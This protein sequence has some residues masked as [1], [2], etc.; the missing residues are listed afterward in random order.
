MASSEANLGEIWRVFDIELHQHWALYLVEGAVL[1]VLGATAIVLPPLATLAITVMLGWVLL[2]SGIIGLVTT[3]GAR[4][5][6]GFGWSLVSG[7]LAVAV[8]GVLLANAEIAAVFLTL[9]LLGFFIIE[10]GVS[11]MFALSHRRRLSSSRWGWMVASGIFD[12]AVGGSIVM[13]PP[14]V[15]PGALGFLVGVNLLFGGVALIAMAERAHGADKQAHRSPYR[16][17]RRRS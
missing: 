17:A 15:P 3:F 14:V 2:V 13:G 6:V 5:A 8:G 1:I 12:L 7:V 4:T 16:T 9:V 10:G 11:I